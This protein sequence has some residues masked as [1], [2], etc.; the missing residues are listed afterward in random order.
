MLVLWVTTDC[1]LRCRYCYAEGGEKPEYMSWEVAKRALDFMREHSEGFKVQLAGGEPLLNM[2]LVEQVVRYTPNWRVIHQLQTNATLITP[3]V[4]RR[5]KGLELRIGVSL[6]GL[7]KVNDLLRPFPDGRGA[8]K[9]AI[10]G[11][12]NLGRRGIRVGLTCVLS[13]ESA[14][15]LAGLVQL[16]SYLGNV[17]GISLDVLRPTGRGS[18]V[19]QADSVEAAHFLRLAL[20][21]ADELVQMGGRRVK[22]REAERL[23]LLL[24]GKGERHFRCYFDA[25]AQLVVKPNGDAYPCAS[26]VPFPEFLLGNVLE[27]DFGRSLEEKLREKREL[28]SLPERCLSC[29]EFWLCQGP[30]PAWVYA[31]RRMGGEDLVECSLKK[32][33]LSYVRREEG[34]PEKTGL[35][36]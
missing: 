31:S 17:E 26:L 3:E 19:R 34:V 9:A 15:G 16:L 33:F 22:F 23:R 6:D 7:P 24:A 30:C 14:P 11:I 2:G 35:P 21:R 4:A 12:E 20:K 18:K 5:I 1:N 10:A 28:I 25:C 8:T 27:K 13:E 32:T 36:V 29:P